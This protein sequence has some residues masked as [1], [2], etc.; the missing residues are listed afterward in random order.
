MTP[1]P[2]VVVVG[3][4]FGGLHAVKALR[5]EPV[6]VTLIDRQNYHLFRPLL[7]QVAM[8]GLSPADIAAPL[9]WIFRGVKNVCTLLGEVTEIDAMTAQQQGLVYTPPDDPPV[10]PSDDRQGAEIAAGFG[11]AIEEEDDPRAELLPEWVTNNDEDLA[12]KVRTAIHRNSETSTMTDIEV[13]VEDG[14]VYLTGEV[15]TLDE[16]DIL[17]TLVQDLEGVDYVEEELD[18][19]VL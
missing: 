17:V 5:G 18:V 10:I 14:I 7:Y 13:S 2:R 12:D 9:R 6:Q 8:A 3:G 16:I 1:Q 4:G 15:E 11:Q 19:R